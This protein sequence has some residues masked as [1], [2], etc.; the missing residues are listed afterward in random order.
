MEG[1]R[2]GGADVAVHGLV[3]S[4]ESLALDDEASRSSSPRVI[5]D[6]GLV[7]SPLREGRLGR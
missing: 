4:L 3:D 2:G 7:E 1:G 6:L 5:G